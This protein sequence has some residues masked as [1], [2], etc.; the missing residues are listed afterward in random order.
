[1]YNLGL[2]EVLSAKVANV[3]CLL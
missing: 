2:L 1:M 3:Y